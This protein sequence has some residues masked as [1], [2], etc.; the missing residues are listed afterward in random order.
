[1]TAAAPLVTVCVPTIGRMEYLPATRASIEAQTFED[2]EILILD[3][4][5]PPAAA[6]ALARWAAEDPR[7]RVLRA[8]P[9]VPMFANFN[10][11]IA[12]ARG[13][14]LAYFHDDDVYLPRFLELLVGALEDHPTAA[15]SASNWGFIDERGEITEERR[16][17][18]ETELWDGK[19]YIRELAGRGRNP[20]P[21][22]G[23]V[24][25]VSAFGPEGIDERVS[26]HFGDF[27]VLMRL[28]ERGGVA[29]IADTA[30]R[31]RRHA[32]QAS[33][34]VPLS[35]AIVMRTEILSA[36]CD[37]YLARWPNDA[38]F[39]AQLR[40]RIALAHRFG[41]VWGWLIG[42]DE[43]E[44]TAC[45]A[46]LEGRTIDRPLRAMLTG[47]QRLGLKPT[48]RPGKLVQVARKVAGAL[49]V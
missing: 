13:K 45:V 28:A 18:K 1:M 39:V 33:G 47:V 2:M 42:D 16:W 32:G 22:P 6:E 36:Y 8:D 17:I 21:M 3:N 14:Y 46:G 41:L 38:A 40:Q 35:R 30:M 23:V 12:A 49:G 25:R 34:T 31:V 10:R 19:R 26:I 44:A 4:A 43:R 7:V 24:Y 9:R 27:V 48:V 20:I 29:M 11:G 5:S 15:F 37:E